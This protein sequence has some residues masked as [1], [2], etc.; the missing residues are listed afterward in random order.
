MYSK[1]FRLALGVALAALLLLPVTAFGEK[2]PVLVKNYGNALAFFP[3]V[4]AA[5]MTLTITGPCNYKVR[6]SLKEDG[7]LY[8][9]LDE[10]TIDGMYRFEVTVIPEIDNSVIEVLQIARKTG[11]NSEVDQ[12]CRD[13]KLPT[14]PQTQNSGFTVFRSEIIY[15]PNQQEEGSGP[16]LAEGGLAAGVS[17]LVTSQS[18]VVDQDVPSL[19][20]DFVIND[21][22]IVDGSACI[23]F[24]CVNGESFSFDT[25]RLKENNLR[26]KF[27][28]TSVAAGFPRTDWQLTANASANGGA[29]KF[30]I[31]DI[32]GSRTP[33]T[34][35][36][37]ARSHSLYVDDGGRIGNRTSTPST[38]IHTIDGDTP[39][40]RLQQDGSSG[41]APQTW[42]VA[43]NETNFF[44]RDVTNGSTLPFRIRPGAPTS[45]IFVDVNGNVGLGTASPSFDL[46]I[47]D[48]SAAANF[49]VQGTSGSMV[50][51]DTDATSDEQ[52]AQ[53]LNSS[54]IFKLR[55]LDDALANQTRRGYALDMGT[56]HMGIAC[57]SNIDS[58]LVV[59]SQGS[60]NSGT[61][62]ELNAG[63][64]QFT[65]S[66]SRTLK[67]NLSRVEISNILDRVSDVPVYRYDFIEGPKDRLGLVAEDFHEVFSRGSEKVLSG[68]EVQMALW[69]AVQELTA[70][71]E[72]LEAEL[73]GQDEVGDSSN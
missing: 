44:I 34:V 19:N 68:Q 38:E 52:A 5:D 1:S 51:V 70:K 71:V 35:E 67:E 66:S 4:E 47:V 50:L 16:K 21:D 40:L 56:G 25:I 54:G 32:S 69:L 65:A 9:K 43:G 62:S 11:D 29:S 13:G 49:V 59:G 30:S 17:G 3:Q 36:A 26:I 8:F 42:D 57:D 2:E 53:Q 63:D 7:E 12:L 10:T 24:D 37:N 72:M 14:D 73:A 20:K 46:D 61:R 48:T 39:T 22:L 6:R 64:T 45:S 23:G 33:F 31:D 60:C 27:D 55:F 28:D 58:D 18:A 15:D 41:F